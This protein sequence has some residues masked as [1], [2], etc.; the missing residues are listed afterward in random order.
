[1]AEF[2]MNSQNEA[3]PEQ[4]QY[5]KILEIGMYLGL[6][7]L[8]ITF[9]LYVFGIV[10]PYIPMNEL[11]RYWTMNVHDYLHTADIHPGWN[12]IGMLEYGDFLNFVGIALLAVVTII[13]YLAIIPILLRRKDTVYAVLALLEALVLILAASGILATGAH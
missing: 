5:A 2:S 12:W 8:F 10:K 13:C 6:L 3:T 9:M 11:P 4:L 1:M 7:I